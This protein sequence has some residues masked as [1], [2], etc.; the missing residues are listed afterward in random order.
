MLAQFVLIRLQQLSSTPVITS[1]KKHKLLSLLTFVFRGFCE[2]CSGLLE[3]CPMCRSVIESVRSVNTNSDQDHT[4][5][6][7]PHASEVSSYEVGCYSENLDGRSYQPSQ[8][9]SH[10]PSNIPI[11]E[12]NKDHLTSSNQLLHVLH[13]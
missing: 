8:Q 6:Q 4:Q 13:T 1:R 10:S 5:S 2:E 9:E 3:T 12:N 11:T 7:Q